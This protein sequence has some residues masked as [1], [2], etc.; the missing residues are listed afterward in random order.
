[1]FR[2]LNHLYI[3]YDL[4]FHSAFQNLILDPSWTVPEASWAVLEAS[5]AVLEAPWDILGAS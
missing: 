2:D 1:M 3:R 4:V 5:W